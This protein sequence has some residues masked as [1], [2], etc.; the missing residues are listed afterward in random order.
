MPVYPAG[1]NASCHVAR[2]KTGIS[3]CRTR[4]SHACYVVSDVDVPF[5]P[6]TTGLP[7]TTDTSHHR[8]YVCVYV[9]KNPSRKSHIP[10]IISGQCYDSRIISKL[11]SQACMQPPV[12]CIRVFLH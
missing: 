9:F 1:C 8:S 6:W 11:K 12:C 2:C 10:D 7:W 3:I 5:F 4:I